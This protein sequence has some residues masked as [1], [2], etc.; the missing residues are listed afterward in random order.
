MSLILSNRATK[1]QRELLH[2]LEY[3]GS[4]DLTVTQAARLIDELFEEKRLADNDQYIEL[5]GEQINIF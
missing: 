3:Y 1:K 4:Y 2:K 5:N